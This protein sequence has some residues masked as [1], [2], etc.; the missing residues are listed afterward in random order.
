VAGKKLKLDALAFGA[1]PDDVELGCAGTL[2]KLSQQGYSTGIVDLTE[3]EMASRGTVEQRHKESAEAAKILGSQQ[4][5]NL[6]M[7]DANILKNETNRDKIIQAVR[8]YRPTIVFAPYPD[9]RH[10]D[11]IHA[12]NLITEG[13]FYAGLKKILPDIPHHRPHKVVYYMLTYEFVPTFVVDIS[14][15]FE[16]KM[17]AL[18]TYRSQFYNPDW[19]GTKTFVSSKWFMEALEFRARHFGWQAGV[20]YGEPFHIRELIALDDPFK[21]L[22]KNIM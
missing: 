2:L 9:D 17:N 18:K 19:P 22:G 21:V 11:H 16:G 15:Q 5:E 1:H 13:C 6:K 3:G 14:E 8:K 4:R 12:S 10:P 7:P 20:K